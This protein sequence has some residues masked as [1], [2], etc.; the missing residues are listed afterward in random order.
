MLILP[1]IYDK[2]LVE[3][4]VRILDEMY[5]VKRVHNAISKA[6]PTTIQLCMLFTH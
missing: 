4:C 6:I 2:S 3:F 5:A 1:L